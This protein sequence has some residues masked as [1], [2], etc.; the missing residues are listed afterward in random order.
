MLQCRNYDKSFGEL[1]HEIKILNRKEENDKLREIEIPQEDPTQGIYS[2]ESLIALGIEKT[3]CL[4][5]NR[6]K[7]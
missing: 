2:M 7:N 5:G 4:Q 1:L 6:P 3:K